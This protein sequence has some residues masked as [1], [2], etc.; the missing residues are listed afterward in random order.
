MKVKEMFMQMYCLERSPRVREY[1]YIISFVTRHATALIPSHKA[2][3]NVERPLRKN[4]ESVFTVARISWFGKE[5]SSTIL[6]FLAVFLLELIRKVP[7]FI[8][9]LLCT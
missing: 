9:L 1:V 7:G 4:C 3:E 2:R 8:G 6:V 5:M